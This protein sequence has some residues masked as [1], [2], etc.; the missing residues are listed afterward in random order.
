MREIPTK[1]HTRLP[2]VRWEE[3]RVALVVG[4]ADYEFGDFAGIVEDVP[5]G[6]VVGGYVIGVDTI[7]VRHIAPEV[8]SLFGFRD[9]ADLLAG[10]SRVYKTGLSDGIRVTIYTLADRPV[11]S[12]EEE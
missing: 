1:A 12:W 9:S 4:E 6:G 5:R 2:I 11:E 8:A 3:Y 10:L 7:E